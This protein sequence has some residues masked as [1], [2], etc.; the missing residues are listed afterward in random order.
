MA[1]KTRYGDDQTAR[2]RGPQRG[3]TDNHAAGR[4]VKVEL[5]RA[6]LAEIGAERAH[7]FDAFAGSGEMFRAVWREAAGY[8][9]CDTRWFEDDRLAFVADN[10]RV[11]RAIELRP[12]TVF[13][14]DAYGSPWEQALILAARRPLKRGE[15]IGIALTEGSGTSIRLATIPAPFARLAGVD[16]R[17]AGAT[18][19]HEELVER[20]IAGLAKRM[21]A[22]VARRWH[23]AGKS[24]AQVKYEA[25]ILESG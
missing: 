15:R 7:V 4:A 5:R 24:Q 1:R 12:F 18:R 9:A 22:Q 19:S 23:G 10:R 2:H 13:D 14:L 11:M 8:V 21:R 16:P 3:G 17:A 6:M 25:M 20:A